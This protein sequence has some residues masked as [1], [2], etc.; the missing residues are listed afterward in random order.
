MR[1]KPIYS[2][3]RRHR[4]ALAAAVWILTGV[5]LAAPQA[6]QPARADDTKAMVAHLADRSFELL[7]SL[8]A[9]TN[10]TD[11]N[12]LLGAIASF[13]SDA[14]NLSKSLARG[15]SAAAS[16][17]ID[18]LHADQ[19]SVDKLLKD[20]PGALRAQDWD[21]MRQQ[22]ATLAAQIPHVATARTDVGGIGPPESGPAATPSAATAPELPKPS[23]ASASTPAAAESAAGSNDAPRIVIA[24]RETDGGVTRL[25]G[26]F[27]GDALK[28]AGIYEG[29][30]ELRSFKVDD[31]PGRQKVEFDLSLGEASAATRLR[32]T[33]AEGRSAEASAIDSS[34]AEPATAMAPPIDTT[35][36]APSSGG[37]LESGV[38]VDRG[39]G[40]AGAEDSASVAEIP[41]H[42]PPV[43]SPSKRHSLG[44]KLGNVRIEIAGVTRTQNLPPAYEIVGQII[45]TGVTRAGIFV[46]GRMT[47]QI[48]IADSADSTAFDQRLMA[49]GGAVTVRAYG[50]GD[51]F[52]ETQ[53]DLADA[54]ENTFVSA[55]PLTPAGPAIQITAVSP[56]AVN[57][58]QVSGVISGRSIAS[59]GLYQ[60]GA[61]AQNLSLGGGIAGIFG[62]L[63][64]GD[65]RSLNF[66]TRFNPAAGPASI[67]A[68]DATG[69]YTE[70]PIVIAGASPYGVSPYSAANP[71]GGASRS[72][73]YYGPGSPRPLPPG[74]TRPLW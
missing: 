65:Y 6:V 10:R 2:A 5:T 17:A 16:S 14:Q 3:I 12:P 24:S 68:F 49:E 22:L 27:E 50:V 15:D 36:E 74:S 55:A 35:A 19:T 57:L 34:S 1:Q 69:A 28:S 18:A 46:N 25:R 32:V 40:S 64:P 39:L 59:A 60:N 58:Y 29:A 8:N 48:P 51:Q 56:L 42:G 63:I 7:G 53:V 21:G 9:Q 66:S 52:T 70:Q 31:V 71:Y 38:E 72:I 26:F 41:S 61:L 33:D 11:S 62:A 73:P 37:A 13:A 20:H 44:G 45:G 47:Q 43:P 67:R 23:A 54:G 4:I 30:S